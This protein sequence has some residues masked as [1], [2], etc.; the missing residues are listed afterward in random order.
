MNVSLKKQANKEAAEDSTGTFM[1]VLQK[2]TKR[3]LNKCDGW[4]W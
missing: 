3:G 4:C 2:K 1:S